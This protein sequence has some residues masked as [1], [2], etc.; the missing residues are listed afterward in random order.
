MK[1]NHHHVKLQ[2]AKLIN[3]LSDEIIDFP[4]QNCSKQNISFHFINSKTNKGKLAYI[5]L[6]YLQSAFTHSRSDRSIHPLSGEVRY[7]FPSSVGDRLRGEFK[8]KSSFP[9]T[10]RYLAEHFKPPHLF[11]FEWSLWKKDCLPNLN[12]LT[13]AEERIEC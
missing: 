11:Y 13:N 5:F 6:N 10:A 12:T 2:L 1:P 9:Y 8:K 7:L 3:I 4:T